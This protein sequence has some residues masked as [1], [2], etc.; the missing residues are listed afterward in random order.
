MSVLQACVL[1]VDF[2]DKVRKQGT[3]DDDDDDIGMK[4]NKD[5]AILE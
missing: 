3:S 2:V 1:V 5:G 4:G